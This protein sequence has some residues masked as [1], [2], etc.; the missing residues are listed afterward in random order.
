MGLHRESKRG[1]M[2]ILAQLYGRNELCILSQ[3]Q[4]ISIQMALSHPIFKGGKE[5]HL[6]VGC[7]PEATL[8]LPKH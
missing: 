3:H 2:L 5:S 7:S 4:T 8:T 6:G 1:V